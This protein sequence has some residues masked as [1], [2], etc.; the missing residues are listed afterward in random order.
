MAE[1]ECL[2]Q[3][4]IL[5]ESGYCIQGW[6]HVRLNLHVLVL[7]PPCRLHTATLNSKYFLKIYMAAVPNTQMRWSLLRTIG[8]LAHRFKKITAT[9]K[10]INTQ[11]FNTNYKHFKMEKDLSFSYTR[12]TYNMIQFFNKTQRILIRY[13]I[14]LLRLNSSP[15]SFWLSS[16]NSATA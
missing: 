16:R 11:M 6:S 3:P 14:Y 1:N 12:F 15:S 7:E 8:N 9:D 10:T 2:P 13:L 4:K 5:T